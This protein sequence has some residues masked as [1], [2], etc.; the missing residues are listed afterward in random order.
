LALYLFCGDKTGGKA[1]LK[2]LVKLT[3]GVSLQKEHFNIMS[4]D[5]ST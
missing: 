5:K 3:T 2:M 4:K 1:A